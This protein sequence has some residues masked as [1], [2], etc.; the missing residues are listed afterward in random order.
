[1][2]DKPVRRGRPEKGGTEKGGGG[3]RKID[4]AVSLYEK[5][6]ITA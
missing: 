4:G 3:K 1:V 6:P 5:K 2:N